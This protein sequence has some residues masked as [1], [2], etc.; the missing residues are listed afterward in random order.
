MKYFP[1]GEIATYP[2]FD[3]PLT[4]GGRVGA[5]VP[6]V[7]T[8]VRSCAA[9]ALLPGLLTTI[10]PSLATARSYAAPLGAGMLVW[11]ARPGSSATM[12]SGCWTP[13]PSGGNPE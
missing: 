6:V 8:V 9:A 5:G 10:R 1:F 13:P 3:T 7:S 11:R 2:L 4:P 12:I